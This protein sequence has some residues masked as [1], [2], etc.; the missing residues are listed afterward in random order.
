MPTTTK[1][2]PRAY[3]APRRHEMETSDDVVAICRL[4]QLGWGRR[5]IATRAG[6]RSQHREALHPRGRLEPHEGNAR[7]SALR[8]SR[9]GSSISRPWCA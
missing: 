5:R 9:G 8:T 4:H 6:D 3:T 1:P 7:I 2:L